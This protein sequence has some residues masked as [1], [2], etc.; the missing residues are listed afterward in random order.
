MAFLGVFLQCSSGI[1]ASLFR[2]FG[3]MACVSS[4]FPVAGS[5]V[6]QLLQYIYWQL[7]G[8]AVLMIQIRVGVSGVNVLS[9]SCW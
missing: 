4:L 9:L 5:V 1:L 2:D 8:L 3:S 6:L 7:Y